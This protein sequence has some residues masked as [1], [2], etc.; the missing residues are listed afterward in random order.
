LVPW[1]GKEVLLALNIKDATAE[2]LAADI[3][4]LTGENKTQAIRTSLLERKERLELRTVDVPAKDRF[5][6][7]LETVIWPHIPT[8]EQGR[9]LTR[10]E[11]EE[12]LGYGGEGV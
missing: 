12:I 1:D 5:L 7:F 10:K 11:R 8:A 9:S 4:A 6:C 3:A 2:K